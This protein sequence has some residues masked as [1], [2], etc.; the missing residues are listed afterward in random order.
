MKRARKITVDDAT[1][2]LNELVELDKLALRALIDLRT[3]CNEQLADHPTAQVASTMAGPAIGMLGV[4][5]GLFGVD[6]HGWG[7]ITA[8][9]SDEDELVEFRKTGTVTV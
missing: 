8:I 2:Y 4:L 9:V 7:F 6:E 5:N 1:E 3:P